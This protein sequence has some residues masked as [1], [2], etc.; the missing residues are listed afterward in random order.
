VDLLFERNNNLNNKPNKN[1]NESYYKNLAMDRGK[2]IP[3][4]SG[5]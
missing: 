2:G 5:F 4:L 3:N 1:A